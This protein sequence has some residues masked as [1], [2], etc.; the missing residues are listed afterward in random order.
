MDEIEKEVFKKKLDKLTR[1]VNELFTRI[2]DM[3]EQLN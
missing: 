1:D 2:E 3:E